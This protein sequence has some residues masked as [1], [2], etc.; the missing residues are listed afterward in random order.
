MIGF[1]IVLVGIGTFFSCLCF[2]LAWVVKEHATANKYRHLIRLYQML[3]KEVATAA[4]GTR[5]K[6]IYKAGKK[7]QDLIVK[8]ETEAEAMR[9]F[10]TVT[11][12]NYDKIMELGK[13]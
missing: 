3:P 9:Q 8:A 4:G 7:R 11:K 10:I 2:F 5:W 6:F 12:G 13:I 1:F